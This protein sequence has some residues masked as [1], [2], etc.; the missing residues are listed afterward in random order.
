MYLYYHGSALVQALSPEIQGPF[1]VWTYKQVSYARGVY[2]TQETSRMGTA[3][4]QKQDEE[5]DFRIIT[6]E[7]Y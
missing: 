3:R 7:Y 4:V 5:A 6:E 2:P 1:S